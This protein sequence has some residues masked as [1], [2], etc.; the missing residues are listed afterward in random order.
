VDLQLTVD[1]RAG[2]R[3]ARLYEQMR[4]AMLD[5]RLRAGDRLPPTRELAATLGVARGTVA[6]VYDRLTAEGFVIGRVGSGT[7]VRPDVLPD[8]SRRAPGG[9]VRPRP[10]WG[11]LPDPVPEPPSAELDL[12][13][14]G[15]DAS[16]FPLAAWRRLVSQTLRPSL[17]GAAP[18]DGQGDAVLRREIAR[19]LSTSRSVRA[20]G[21]DV[22]VT[23]GAQQGLDIVARAVLAPG[24]I[25]VV[26]DPGYTAAVRLFASHAATV[27]GVEVDDEGLIVDRLPSRARLIYLTPSHQFPTGAVLS[28][29]R[30]QALL[31][32]ARR[33][34]VIVVED[35]YDSEFRWQDRPLA[36]LQSLDSCGRVVY[37]GSFSKILMPSLRVG[38]VIAPR[39]LQSVLRQAKQ[40]TD[41][42]GD[43]VTQGAL[44]RFLAEGILPAHQ[45]R[46]SKVYA[47]RRAALLAGLDA[48]AAAGL[49]VQP[50]AA[51]LHVCCW[52]DDRTVDDVEFAVR[53]A[54]VGVAVDP[55]STRF[56]TA[57]AR[58]GLAMGFR[59]LPAERVPEAVRRLITVL[60]GYR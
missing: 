39:S 53:A 21:E 25:A 13:V 14:G 36:P 54:A 20:G 17:L 38:Y 22:V 52:F 35:D 48:L 50:N 19:Y 28:L 33:R 3:T 4:D 16:L 41:W 26:E 32:W 18:Y 23:N 5:G 51:G 29:A 45:R 49:R 46:V 2:D 60:A 6:T 42:Q 55:I 31:D 11:S 7:F 1:D 34:D 40:L 58:P 47:A 30:R 56:I 8:R 10:I 24:D 37:V 15:P 12:S 57:P 9:E 43:A 27:V 44:A 59:R